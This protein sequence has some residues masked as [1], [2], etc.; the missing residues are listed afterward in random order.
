MDWIDDESMGLI[1][2]GF[3]DSFV[4]CEAFQGLEPASEVVCRN[5]VGEVPAKL[6]V[7]VVVEAVDGRFFDGPVHSFDL[8]VSPRVVGF[9]QTMFDTV[10]P[11][12]L[13]EA[14]HTV[15][16]GPAIAVTRQIGELDAV[17][18]EYGVQPV[19]HR[20][21]RGLQEP[22]SG[23]PVGLRMQLDE[24]EF[25]GAIDRN[26][27]V[28]LTFAGANLGDVDVEIA[29]GVDFEFAFV[30]LKRD[31]GDPLPTTATLP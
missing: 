26:E 2:P 20:R 23:W 25:G 22:H 13:V 30:R 12:D 7:C 9:G 5:E 14:V 8:A 28:E 10:G 18:G 11:A 4:G 17:I 24:S 3:A 1:R 31:R 16:G 27:E 21:D 15:T 6:V 19:R 29:D